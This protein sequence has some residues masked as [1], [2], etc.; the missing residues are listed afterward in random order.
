MK[1]RNFEITGE[2]LKDYWANARTITIEKVQYR[3]GKMSY[4]DYF[5]EPTGWTGGEKDGFAP[6]TLWL[7]NVNPKLDVYTLE[8]VK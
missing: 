6:G 1:V 5:L 3:I 7:I 2:R 8:E 4:G